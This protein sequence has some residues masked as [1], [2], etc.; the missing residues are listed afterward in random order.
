MAVSR[1]LQALMPE[2]GSIDRCLL[3]YVAVRGVNPVT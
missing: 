2:L 1:T 3:P